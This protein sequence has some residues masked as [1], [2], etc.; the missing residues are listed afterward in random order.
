MLM[1]NKHI[2]TTTS[3]SVADIIKYTKFL[4]KIVV[5][6]TVHPLLH[7]SHF[8]NFQTLRCFQTPHCSQ[9]HC[10]QT[11]HYFQTPRS[12]LTHCSLRH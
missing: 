10:S 9:T 4:I 3:M 1:D 8:Q 5:Y 12:L 7:C 6:P 2:I 11:P